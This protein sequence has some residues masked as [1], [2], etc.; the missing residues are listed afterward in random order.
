MRRLLKL[1]LLKLLL[2]LLKLLLLLLKL[3]PLL[4]L[5]KL[6]L[7]PLLKL[8]QSKH[9]AFQATKKP[10]QVGFFYFHR[11]NPSGNFAPGKSLFLRRHPHPVRLASKHI[12]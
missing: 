2:L 3:H 7:L 9:P 4:L 10:T 1:L 8:L 11:L 6:L 5:Q 12:A